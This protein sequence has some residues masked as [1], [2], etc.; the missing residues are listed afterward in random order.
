MGRLA[1]WLGSLGSS[2]AGGSPRYP[3]RMAGPRRAGTEAGRADVAVIIHRNDALDDPRYF[4]HEISQVWRRHGLRVAVV[5]DVGPEVEA[6]LAILHVNLTVVPDEYLRLAARYPT[7]LNGSVVDIS[8][9][10]FSADL[11]TRRD[12]YDGPV[13]VKTDRNFGGRPEVRLG[14]GGGPGRVWC[15]AQRDRLPWA[16]RSH[17][18]GDYPIFDSP[19]QVPWAA[20]ANPTYVVERFLPEQHEGLYCLRTWMFLGDRETHSLSFSEAPIVKSHGVVRREPLGEVPEELWARRRELGFDF[21]KFD[22]ALVD[23]RVVLYDTNRT[24]ALGDVSEDV[25]ARNIPLLA[26][27]LDSCR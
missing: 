16:F 26:A 14:V 5:D 9:R 1:D 27:G 25:L 2:L 23:G 10:R 19:A 3:A 8:K 24:P 18:V 20:W 6:D 21:G 13:I 17:L 11:V 22:Y 4:L 7:V 15:R 12:G